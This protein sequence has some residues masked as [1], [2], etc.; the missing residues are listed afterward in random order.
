ML[1]Q[2]PSSEKEIRYLWEIITCP[3]PLYI[4]ESPKFIVSFVCVDAI[5]HPNQ[6]FFNHVGMFLVFLG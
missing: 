5:I 2:K 6:H 3:D 4:M 1:S